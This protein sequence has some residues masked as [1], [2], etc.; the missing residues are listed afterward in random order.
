MK[1]ILQEGFAVNIVCEPSNPRRIA[2][3]FSL[4]LLLIG[5]TAAAGGLGFWKAYIEPYRAQRE[6]IQVFQ[7]AGATVAVRPAGPAWLRP[8][9]GDETLRT[10]VHVDLTNCPVTDDCLGW[11]VRLPDLEG[12]QIGVSPGV[13]QVVPGNLHNAEH[14][15][16]SGAKVTDAGLVHLRDCSNLTTLF[17]W[18]T[19]VSDAGL[20]HLKEIRSLRFVWL[21]GTKVTPEGARELRAALPHAYVGY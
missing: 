7:D 20:I 18:R 4:R 21:N 5:V 11:L 10:I 15:N 12:F 6:A 3:R 1:T 19:Q 14:L 13:P 8:I 9:V 2:I 16:L 17:L